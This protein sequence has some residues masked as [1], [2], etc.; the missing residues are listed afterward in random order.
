MKLD[1][2]TNPAF[3][4]LAKD[5]F[6][7]GNS[8]QTIMTRAQENHDRG[9]HDYHDRGC[10]DYH[11]RG[12]DYHDRGVTTIMTGGERQSINL[13]SLLQFKV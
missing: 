7:A 8:K 1:C 2:E 12:H 3:L 11:D 6:L 4:N 5:V 13:I 9:C 10:H